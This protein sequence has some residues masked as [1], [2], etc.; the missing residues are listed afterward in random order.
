M[1]HAGFSIWSV[2]GTRQHGVPFPGRVVGGV[3]GRVG[4]G[5]AVVWGSQK[6]T[7]VFGAVQVRFGSFRGGMNSSGRPGGAVLVG[8]E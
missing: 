4:F 7:H 1:H 8:A 3:R 5:L 2:C 6:L